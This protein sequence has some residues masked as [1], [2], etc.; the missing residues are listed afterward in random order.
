MA[1]GSRQLRV[2][3]RDGGRLGGTGGMRWVALG[4]LQTQAAADQLQDLIILQPNQL[5]LVLTWEQW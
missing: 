3:G 1:A 5:L 2:E 4:R